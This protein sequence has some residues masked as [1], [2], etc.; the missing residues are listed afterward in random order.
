MVRHAS[1]EP[2]EAVAW[3]DSLLTFNTSCWN[4]H[5]SQLSVNYDA[6]SDSYDSTWAEPGINCE[7]CHG[8]GD[9]HIRVCREAPDGQ[10]PVDLRI[11][12]V[13]VFSPA[14]INSTCSS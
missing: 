11:V 12:I 13:R 8:P 6:E 14:Q 7:T 4:C 10:A 9:E 3:T 2:D 5:V 1:R